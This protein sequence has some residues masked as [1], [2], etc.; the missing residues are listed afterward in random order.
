MLGV[1]TDTKNPEQTYALYGDR[2]LFDGSLGSIQRRMLRSGVVDDVRKRLEKVGEGPSLNPG[3]RSAPSPR[4]GVCSAEG[5]RRIMKALIEFTKSMLVGGLLVVVPIYF[6]VLL[7]AKAFAGLIKLL[8][9][10][11]AL[12]PESLHG[13]RHVVAMLI[14]VLLCFAIGLAMRT[15][16]GTRVFR[17]FERRVLEKIPGFG[18]LRGAVRRVSGRSDDAMFQPVLV[19]IEEALT[20][21]SSSRSWTTVAASCSCPRCRRQRPGRSTSCRAT[22]CTGSMLRS[23]R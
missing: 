17:G 1:C 10:V 3:F 8:A 12:L 16:L 15:R 19:E 7:L 6:S 9:P 20:P 13:L 4:G 18:V 2:L 14:V 5:R 23:P 22:A 11:T 21:R